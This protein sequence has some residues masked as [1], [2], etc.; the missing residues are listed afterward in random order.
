MQTAFGFRTF[1]NEKDLSCR[2]Q[3]AWITILA[4]CYLFMAI[5]AQLPALPTDLFDLL[6]YDQFGAA[7]LMLV[8]GFYLYWRASN[9]PVAEIPA[10]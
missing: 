2:P 6:K 3:D 1:P 8:L 7:V 5:V 10:R 4:T 9:P